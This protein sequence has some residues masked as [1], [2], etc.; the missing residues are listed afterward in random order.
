M[1]ESFTTF[2][3][4]AMADYSLHGVEPEAVGNRHPHQAPHG[5]FTCRG[6]QRWIAISVQSD[7][8]WAAL[9]DTAGRPEWRG[10]PRFATAADRCANVE[11]LESLIE[12]WTRNEEAAPL[13][14]K[15]QR[16]GVAATEVLDSADTLADEHLV[17]RGF[18][19]SVDHPEVG[20][21]PMGTT[22][23]RIDG[24]RPT[25]FTPAP[26]LGEHS[27]HVLGDLLQMDR[28][29][30]DDLVRR[31]IVIASDSAASAEV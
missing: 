22:A 16:A 3:P 29:E 21:R 6:D 25:A 31:G 2:I 1:T 12:E 7:E 5:I 30:I 11:A 10:D 18:V 13:A 14:D 28:G 23:W 15:L 17:D 4:Q 20:P 26:L 24:Q 19:A 27:R 9:C 8:A